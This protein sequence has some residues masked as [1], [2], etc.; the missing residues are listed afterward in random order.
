MGPSKY[1]KLVFKVQSLE[2]KL[3]QI[4]KRTRDSHDSSATYST[5]RPCYYESIQNLLELAKDIRHELH[6]SL[7]FSPED[8]KTLKMYNKVGILESEL[9]NM[10]NYIQLFQNHNRKRRLCGSKDSCRGICEKPTKDNSHYSEG[11]PNRSYRHCTSY[12]PHKWKTAM[13]S[14]GFFKNVTEPEY[15]LDSKTLSD[16]FSS[17]SYN[18][19]SSGSSSTVTF[20][21]N[22]KPFYI[23]KSKS[24]YQ[25]RPSTVTIRRKSPERTPVYIRSS[26]ASSGTKRD[27]RKRHQPSLK[28]SSLQF[29]IH[30]SDSNKIHVNANDDLQTQDTEV[31]LVKKKIKPPRS[32]KRY[33][34]SPSSERYFVSRLKKVMSSNSRPL[35]SKRH[36]SHKVKK[37]S[38]PTP[39]QKE[40]KYNFK[41]HNKKVLQVSKYK[42]NDPGLEHSS[43]K[44]SEDRIYSGGKMN[45]IRNNRFGSKMYVD[46]RRSH[47]SKSVAEATSSNINN[48]P[49]YRENHVFYLQDS[50]FILFPKKM[51]S[52]E[53]YFSRNH[54]SSDPYS[55]MNKET[56]K[57]N[58]SFIKPDKI[59]NQHENSNVSNTESNYKIIDSHQNSHLFLEENDIPSRTHSPIKSC[60]K[61]K[62]YETLQNSFSGGRTNQYPSLDSKKCSSY[63]SNITSKSKN[64][65]KSNGKLILLKVVDDQFSHVKDNEGSTLSMKNFNNN[66]K[67]ISLSERLNSHKDISFHDNPFG[68]NAI[69]TTPIYLAT[70]P[71]T[72]PV[73][74]NSFQNQPS[75]FNKTEH[76]FESYNDIVDSAVDNH[77]NKES[78]NSV[79]TTNR[80]HS[81]SPSLKSSHS[82]KRGLNDNKKKIHTLNKSGSK[83]FPIKTKSKDIK[84]AQA[85]TKRAPSL[86]IDRVQRASR[87]ESASDDSKILGSNQSLSNKKTKKWLPRSLSKLS[88]ISKRSKKAKADKNN[89]SLN[90]EGL[91]NNLKGISERVSDEK[92]PSSEKISKAKSWTSL[93]R[94]MSGIG[95]LKK[96]RKRQSTEKQEAIKKFENEE[97]LKKQPFI[98]K[99]MFS[100]N[101]PKSKTKK[102]DGKPIVAEISS[103]GPTSTS[104][105]EADKTSTSILSNH[106]PIITNDER[107]ESKNL[108]GYLVASKINKNKGS[109]IK[110]YNQKPVLTSHVTSNVP[111]KKQNLKDNP[112]PFNYSVHYSKENHKC[113]EMDLVPSILRL[114]DCCPQ[115]EVKTCG[116]KNSWSMGETVL[117]EHKLSEFEKH[118]KYHEYFF[119]PNRCQGCAVHDKKFTKFCQKREEKKLLNNQNQPLNTVCNH[120]NYN[121]PNNNYKRT[122]SV[123][124]SDLILSDSS[125]ICDWKK[126]ANE[127]KECH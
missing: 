3:N 27:K 63:K 32:R 11:F 114:A 14:D 99:R 34:R 36:K 15:I 29:G 7:K 71:Q 66:I 87:N 97:K 75:T 89:K 49:F 101:L 23:R 83:I 50:N 76:K 1:H 67:N 20:D 24:S 55:T 81:T 116:S 80:N 108:N 52:K 68:I 12:E 62:S 10:L 59:S 77:Q 70:V 65:I 38:R 93:K 17:S 123:T 33:S 94:T 13:Y 8:R 19:S 113:V 25:D 115:T 45:N 39:E 105:F 84:N 61:Q 44:Y 31:F 48:V 74:Q 9:Y 78:I 56:T 92:Q 22:R 35:V 41:K 121:V 42:E 6:Y 103:T 37:S 88:I 28:K 111:K 57:F 86:D 53:L 72:L 95:G 69:S 124:T 110:K 4:T 107:L 5:K 18:S 47:D 102:S 96:F 64:N 73:S 54:V 60:T 51:L 90:K 125:D 91:N 127:I 117:S 98:L 126:I 112:K 82:V 46:S 119:K 40:E 30:K 16:S 109:D 43:P 79:N 104:E 100:K 2:N 118:S 106:S 122:P 58:N 26:R 120:D 85:E 21:Q